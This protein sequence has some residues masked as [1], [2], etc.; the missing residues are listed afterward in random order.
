[1]HFE[2]GATYTVL[3][4]QDCCKIQKVSN[5]NTVVI[6]IIKNNNNKSTYIAP[7]QSRL[8]YIHSSI[9]QASKLLRE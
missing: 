3:S 7:D 2:L 9:L 8:L 1:M 5:D 4:V 6:I